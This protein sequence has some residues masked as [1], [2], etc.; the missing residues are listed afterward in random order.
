[1]QESANRRVGGSIGKCL[2]VTHQGLSYKGQRVVIG[3]P[4]SQRL[5]LQMFL[6]V[7]KKP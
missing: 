1:M 4:C 6:A 2:R 5:I 3:E 7:T